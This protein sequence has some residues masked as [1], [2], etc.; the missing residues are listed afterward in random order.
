M[1]GDVFS[2][3]RRLRRTVNEQQRFLQAKLLQFLRPLVSDVELYSRIDSVDHEVLCHQLLR[4][5][6]RKGGFGRSG[7][8]FASCAAGTKLPRA[9]VP[10][11]SA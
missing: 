9:K 10:L 7:P 11:Q 2:R 1:L 3:L 8:A 5:I 6:G 4:W